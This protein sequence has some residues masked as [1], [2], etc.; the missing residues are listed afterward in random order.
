MGVR[1]LRTHA[2][3]LLAQRSSSV[4]DGAAEVAGGVDG[5]GRTAALLVAQVVAQ[6]LACAVRARGEAAGLGETADDGRTGTRLRAGAGG[7]GGAEHRTL[8]EQATRVRLTPPENSIKWDEL[9]MSER[10]GTGGRV[11]ATWTV[12]LTLIH[13]YTIKPEAMQ[14]AQM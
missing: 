13:K 11:A 9:W 2:G 8:L 1:R 4:A 6:A 5:G 7:G 10:L 3:P 12:S 14:I